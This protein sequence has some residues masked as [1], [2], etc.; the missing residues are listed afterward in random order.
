MAALA[1]GLQCL[2]TS[3]SGKKTQGGN[4]NGG[5]GRLKICGVSLSFDGGVSA[6]CV[7]ATHK[8]GGSQDLAGDGF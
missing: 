3:N 4:K 5:D 2:A 8:M 1:A 6:T 7:F